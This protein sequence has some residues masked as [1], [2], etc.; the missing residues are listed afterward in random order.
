MDNLKKEHVRILNRV[1]SIQ[2]YILGLYNYSCDTDIVSIL[3]RLERA[4]DHLNNLSKR[5]FKDN[6]E[7]VLLRNVLKE[8]DAECEWCEEKIRSLGY[9]LDL[10]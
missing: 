8:M 5:Q 6:F 2:N 9:M 7:C 4:F 10:N 3:H 1:V